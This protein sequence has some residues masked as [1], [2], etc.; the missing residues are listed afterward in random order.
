M[1]DPRSVSD[2]TGCVH[3]DTA[4]TIAITS[5][6]EVDVA[7]VSP[8]CCPGVLHD[9]VALALVVGAVADSEHTVVEFSVAWVE[10]ILR[11]V[12]TTGVELE[13]NCVGTDGDRGWSSLN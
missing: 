9:V 12:D 6:D 11:V 8:A 7:L 13:G 1:S 4:G 3:L 10:L 2:G 5:S